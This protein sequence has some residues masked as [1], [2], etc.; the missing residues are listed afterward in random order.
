[1]FIAERKM[2]LKVHKISNEKIERIENSVNSIGSQSFNN[3]TA[4]FLKT[5]K[6][7]GQS[8]VYQVFTI[9]EDDVLGFALLSVIGTEAEILQ[10]AVDKKIRKRGI[11]TKLMK[12]V[13]KWC[14]DN[15]VRSM[16][17]EVRRSNRGAVELY[18]KMSFEVIG[19][20][21]DYYDDPIEDALIMTRRVCCHT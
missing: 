5:I 2:V 3:D 14:A 12:D 13:I 7:R 11:G 10:I 17:L 19:N 20:R 21:K 4:S 6:E 16:Y 1:V 18:K 8:S 9:D 15:S